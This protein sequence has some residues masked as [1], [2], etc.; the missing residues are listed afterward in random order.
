MSQDPAKYSPESVEY[1]PMQQKGP[2]PVTGVNERDV[3]GSF[4][5]EVSSHILRRLMVTD[6]ECDDDEKLVLLLGRINS[7]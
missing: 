4:F 1:Y 5:A 3:M 7:R 2:Q 6:A